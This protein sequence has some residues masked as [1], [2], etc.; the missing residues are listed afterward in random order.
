MDNDGFAVQQ[1]RR[2][3]TTR[4]PGLNSF[5]REG[6]NYTGTDENFKK[7]HARL[8]GREEG[9]GPDGEHHHGSR[10]PRGSDREKLH[11]HYSKSTRPRDNSRTAYENGVL[12]AR[13]ELKR[14]GRKAQDYYERHTGGFAPHQHERL[15]PRATNYRDSTLE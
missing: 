14:M 8:Y 11:T 10:F 15:D 6:L 2:R 9:L 12:A 13:D 7:N 5:L 3:G 4:E 1:R